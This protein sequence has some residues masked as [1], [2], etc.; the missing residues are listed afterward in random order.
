M[1]VDLVH[2]A[3]RLERDGCCT[4]EDVLPED[5][6]ERLRVEIDTGTQS[7]LE[8]QLT[9]GL[10]QVETGSEDPDGGD[11]VL[12]GAAHHIV[13]FGGAFFDLLEAR[14]LFEVVEQHLDGGPFILNSFG[15]VTNT[16][17]RNMYEH[18]KTIHRDSRSFF[19]HFHE[20]CW[21]SVMVDDFTKD[22]GA[23]W[24]LPGSHTRPSAPTPEEFHRDGRQITGR[25]GTV[26]VFDGRLWH[27][28]GKNITDQSRRCLTISFTR[29]FLKPQLDYVRCFG[30]E[31]VEQ[32]SENLK[33]LFG[34]Y[35]RVP[36]NHDEFYKPAAERLYRSG[37][38]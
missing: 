26:V 19:P 29:P 22:N 23:T 20:Q 36:I 14:P 31:R 3:E 17:T 35:A 4:F 25:A 8:M 34:Y 6:L 28:A 13:A 33:Q 16:N 9:R 24:F 27:A 38:G 12:G 37:Q 15:A 7:C 11:G 1:T 5:L 32:M 2:V 18:G 10:G 30:L 21:L